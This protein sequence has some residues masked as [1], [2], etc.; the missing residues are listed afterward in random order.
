LK[1][2]T[3]TGVPVLP[4]SNCFAVL[5]VE[6]CEDNDT[7]FLGSQIPPVREN[8]TPTLK[9]HPH[10]EG[11]RWQI[12]QVRALAAKPNLVVKTTTHPLKVQTQLKVTLT[13]ACHQVKGLIDSGAS[14]QFLDARFMA[15]NQI[16]TLQLPQPMPV[17]N[18]DGTENQAG[19]ITQVVDAVFHVENHSEHTL[20]TV[21]DL[22]DQQMILGHNWLT[23]HN[24]EIDWAKGTLKFTRGDQQ[25]SECAR[26]C[27][28]ERAKARSQ[29]KEARNLERVWRIF[30]PSLNSQIQDVAEEDEDKDEDEEEAQT[31]IHSKVE[32][33]D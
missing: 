7:P 3:R 13:R 27:W 2:Q 29:E 5:P 16:P 12:C 4:M 28:E 15:E 24:P 25:C 32:E 19:A 23:S 22:G 31:P 20:F 17:Y 18:V 10:L 9:I 8:P 26:Q 14:F 33:G 21:T 1:G 11:T 30:T 6:D